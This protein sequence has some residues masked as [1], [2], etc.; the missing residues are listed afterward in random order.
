MRVFY[1]HEIDNFMTEKRERLVHLVQFGKA[2]E[3]R[4]Y[5]NQIL[6]MQKRVLQNK[7][8]F[9]PDKLE[10]SA[11]IP[12]L[13]QDKPVGFGFLFVR[14]GHTDL[15]TLVDPDYQSV[16]IGMKLVYQLEI[17][18]K[19]LGLSE[20]HAFITDKKQTAQDAFESAGYQIKRKESGRILY[21]KKLDS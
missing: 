1:K 20:I 14:S 21:I 19:K 13:V 17:L 5:E 15:M 8:P 10:S 9:L 4:I 11:V 3:P 12:A 16:G 2:S 18:T 7:G 6:E